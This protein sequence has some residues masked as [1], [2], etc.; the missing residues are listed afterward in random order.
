MLKLKLQYFGHLMWITDSLEKTLMLGKIE[1]RRRSGRR[2]WD[3]WMASQSQWTWI[4]ASS[5]RWWRKGKPG[6]LQ[7]MGSQRVGHDWETE[8][9]KSGSW[10]KTESFIL[11]I[12]FL[13]TQHPAYN[14][15]KERT[16][17]SWRLPLTFL[18]WRKMDYSLTGTDS[19]GQMQQWFPAAYVSL[20]RATQTKTAAQS[21]ELTFI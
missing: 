6:V 8:Q 15:S 9:Q 4:W 11:W 16:L 10:M 13:E 14:V 12:S 19:P 21:L 1:H 2:G 5:R 20:C 17:L 3:S 7:S 18:S